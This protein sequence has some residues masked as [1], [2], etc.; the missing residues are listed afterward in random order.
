MNRQEIFNRVIE[1]AKTMNG[2]SYFMENNRSPTCA[3][4]G[5]NGNKCLI[6]AVLPDNLYCPAMESNIMENLLSEYPEVDDYFQVQNEEDVQFL[7]YL[8]ACHDD[9]CSNG[10]RFV[11]HTISPDVFKR[12]L[13]Q[14]LKTF[15]D[16]QGL[17]FNQG[18]EIEAI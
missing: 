15:A 5:C 17:V 3:Y 1:H 16:I 18:E 6:G 12:N 4:R 10:M 14:N 7:S 8:Q 11:P 2:P 9:A 13:M